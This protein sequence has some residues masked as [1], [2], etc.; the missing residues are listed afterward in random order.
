MERLLLV[1]D[2]L[3]LQLCNLEGDR[4][5]RADSIVLELRPDQP[6]RV[7][8]ILVGGPVRQERVGRV[9]VWIGG[10]LRR[11]G[12]SESGGQSEIPFSAVR[13]IGDTLVVDVAEASLPSEHLER[14]LCERIVRRIPGAEGE[15]K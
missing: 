13:K 3:D 6:P 14:W 9:S 2:V 10:L 12:R 1:H 15:R 4:I 7:A 8:T 11:I 5:G